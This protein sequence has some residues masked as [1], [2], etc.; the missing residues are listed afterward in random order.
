MLNIFCW[1]SALTS[2]IIPNSVTSIGD[3]AFFYCSRLTSITIPNSITNIGIAM[4]QGCTSL[5]FVNIPNSVMK[6]DE[7]AFYNCS[8]LNSITIPN[9]VTSI[10]NSA[11]FECSSLNSVTIPNSVTS[12]GMNAFAKC[13]GLTSIN[14]PNNVTYIGSGA[15][16]ECSGLTSVISNME[17]PCS[18][19]LGCFYDDVYNYST[20]YV[21]IGTIDK[22]K[23]TDYWSRFVHIEEGLPSGINAIN[24]VEGGSLHEL[25]RY[26]VKGNSLNSPQK[27]L[28]IIRMSD[29]STK[30]LLIK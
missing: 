23:T 1:C 10:G 19:T 3:G 5:K 12:I 4:F 7:R 21:P 27:G 16:F 28:N 22:Y 14:I 9:S 13:C 20:L 8:G 15:F 29:G 11:F 25:K 17:N 18:I 2:I 30:K 24:R 26:D 6:I